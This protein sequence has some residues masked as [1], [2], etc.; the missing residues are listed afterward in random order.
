M[1]LLSSNTADT[2]AAPGTR[3]SIMNPLRTLMHR[4]SGG[5]F[6]LTVSRRTPRERLQ[7]AKLV[8]VLFPLII[9]LALYLIFGVE[10]PENA[11]VEIFVILVAASLTVIPWVTLRFAGK[12]DLS[13]FL[14]SGL[15]TT[16]ITFSLMQ[17]LPSGINSLIWGAVPSLCLFSISV[18]IAGLPARFV[19][20]LAAI[21]LALAGLLFVVLTLPHHP[22]L[23]QEEILAG[24]FPASAPFDLQQATTTNDVLARPIALLVVTW[25]TSVFARYFL[26]RGQVG[27]KQTHEGTR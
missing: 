13:A 27:A 14:L 4:L 8:A 2:T 6:W 5:Y 22:S 15:V 23:I 24:A 3:T 1:A 26:T 9:L 17:P 16:A 11:T 18:L 19:C 25:V 7:D 12:V 20:S 21:L 10:V